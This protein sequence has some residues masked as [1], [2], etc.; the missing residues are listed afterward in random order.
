MPVTVEIRPAVDE[1]IQR[2][3]PEVRGCDGCNN[4]RACA[5]VIVISAGERELRLCDWCYRDMQR[6]F[7]NNSYSLGTAA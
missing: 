3:S 7:Y 1:K 4:T 6:A 2:V 5:Q